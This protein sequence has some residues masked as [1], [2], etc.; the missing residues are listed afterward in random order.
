MPTY[1]SL[2]NDK[3]RFLQ[4]SQA[5]LNKL[6]VGGENAGKAIEGAFYLTTDSHRLYVGRKDTSISGD[7]VFP[8]QVSPG[9]SVVA[10]AGSLPSTAAA[11]AASGDLYY[12]EDGNILAALKVNNDGTKEWVQVNP[13]TGV[14]GLSITATDSSVS[15]STNQ[16]S[17]TFGLQAEGSAYMAAAQPVVLKAGQN[18]ELTTENNTVTIKSLSGQLN[19]NA[20]TNDTTNKAEVVLSD[21][22]HHFND[23]A[24]AFV[25]GNAD[26][27]VTADETNNEIVISGPVVSGVKPDAYGVAGDSSSAHGFKFGL[28][29]NGTDRDLDTAQVKDSDLDPVIA[30]GTNSTAYFHGGQA[31]LDVYTKAEADTAIQNKINEKLQT[32][33]AMTYKGLINSESDIP[34]ITDASNGD[35]WK[36][37]TG[38]QS[39]TLNTTFRAGDLIIANGTEGSNGKI[40]SGKWDVIPAGD[41]PTY[42][43]ETSFGTSG[44][45]PRF[46]ITSGGTVCLNVGFDNANSTKIKAYGSGTK[47]NFKVRL[48]HDTTDRTDT[49]NANLGAATSDSDSAGGT[50]L[51]FF[52]L[53]GSLADGKIAGLQT[54][55]YGHVT[56]VQGKVVTFKHNYISKLDT[57]FSSSDNVGTILVAP[58]HSITAFNADPNASAS[59]R[60][61]SDS[62]KVTNKTVTVN[63]SSVDALAVDI[64][65]ESF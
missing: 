40:T 9:V 43:F 47:E 48:S 61:T 62:L 33:D 31:N 1:D 28:R 5:D 14:S 55:T 32:A 44:A 45:D 51:K 23:T 35:T 20:K 16:A 13:K 42:N 50:G 8:V 36:I 17:I 53:S 46:A 21:P 19:L 18:I 39:D 34:A 25:A 38:F 52:A 4:G 58:T 26:T 2:L 59:L 57:S 22:D 60:F 24:T 10:D 6:F 29:V 65:W 3:V 49:T 27:T 56:G 37:A 15:G 30:Y 12:I 11:E 63:G 64:V 54:D 41:E 7:N